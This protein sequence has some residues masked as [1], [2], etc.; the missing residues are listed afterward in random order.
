MPEIDLAF[1]DFERAY[2]DLPPA[3]LR[4]RFFEENPFQGK[5][6][7]AI[8]RPATTSIGNYGAGPIR[9]VFSQPGLFGGALFFVSGNQIFRRDPDGNTFALN[10]IIYGEGEVSMCVVKGLDYERLFI[11]D[12][13]RLQFYS[14]GTKASGIVEFTGG[15]NAIAGDQV[16]INATYYEFETPDGFGMVTDGIGASSNPFKVAIGV[17]WD[18]TLD[19]LRSALAFDGTSGMTYSSTIAGQNL[20]VTASY[21][22]PELTITAR[23]DT[24]AGNLFTLTNP[25]DTGGNI[26]VPAGGL[27]TGGNNHGINGIEMPDGLPP[28]QVG[29]LKSYVIVAV[30][31]T[32]RFYWVAPA[33]VTIGALDFATA[34][35]A[36][37]QIVSLQIM[38]D[39]VW[40]VGQTVTEIW[41]TTGDIA[42]PFSPVSG[43]VYDR[44]ALPGTVVNIKGTLYLV[45]QDYIVYA[46][47]GGAQRVSNHGIEE[48]IRLAV[49]AES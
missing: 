5:K 23:I 41:Y 30:G 32:D 25:V 43:R 26:Q 8:A 36:P 29:T 2:A 22:S 1:S 3:P 35:S 34:E 19:N 13:A 40:F 21:L 9:K 48:Q 49:A 10:G 39:T 46:I 17:D 42:L 44:G 4:N 37:D 7:A 15:A 38:Q 47:G 27:F 33:A 6:R 14:G 45:D 11:A 16:E 12:G 20:E 24:E 31:S 28:T 18:E